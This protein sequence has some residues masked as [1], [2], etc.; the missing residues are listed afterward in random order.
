MVEHLTQ[1]FATILSATEMTEIGQY[2]TYSSV[3][4]NLGERI[5]SISLIQGGYTVYILQ[6]QFSFNSKEMD[7]K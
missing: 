4:I 7:K 2:G 6:E 1:W 3:L 5:R